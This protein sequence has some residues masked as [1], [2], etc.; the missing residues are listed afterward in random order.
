[1]LSYLGFDAVST[2]SEESKNPR[3]SV[4][5]G[6]V[7]SII[8]GGAIF[9]VLTYFAGVA[10]PDYQKLNSNTAFLDIL[11]SLGG[12][13]L[14]DLAIVAIVISFGLACSLEGQ[15]AIARILFSM[16][17]DGIL[18]KQ[19]AVVHPKWRTPW[20]ATILIGIVSVVVA[21][22]VGL[23]T[24][25]NWL[26]FGALCG[27]MA[28]NATVVWHFYMK[29]QKTPLSFVKYLVS[30]LI[31]LLVCAYI[32]ANMGTSAYKVGFS[33]LG[34]GFVYLLYKTKLF[35]KPAPVL[36]LDEV[37]EPEATEAEPVAVATEAAPLA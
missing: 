20:V 37:L 11:K 2:L 15:S 8:G 32:F 26:S 33:W 23:A 5:R 22:T 10:Y 30:P 12:T 7:L 17:R 27:F 1:M 4:P 3:K 24:L 31:G 36:Q 18:P 35:S 28:L 34:V 25:A 16:G 21:I 6:T 14:K 19:L 13:P 9:I 29:G